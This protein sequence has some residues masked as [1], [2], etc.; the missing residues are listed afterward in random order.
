MSTGVLQDLM[1]QADDECSLQDPKIDILPEPRGGNLF[2]FDIA[3]A[4]QTALRVLKDGKRWKRC[5]EYK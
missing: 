2:L 1:K 5:S 3:C 4:K